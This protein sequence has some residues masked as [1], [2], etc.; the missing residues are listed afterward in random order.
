MKQNP[1]GGTHLAFC[2]IS[3]EYFT[4]ISC[5]IWS[6]NDCIFYINE[7]MIFRLAPI[8]MQVTYY[9]KSDCQMSINTR[10]SIKWQKRA[11]KRRNSKLTAAANTEIQNTCALWAPVYV[12]DKKKT[13]NEHAPIPNVGF[14]L[15]PAERQYA[16]MSPIDCALFLRIQIFAICHHF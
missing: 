15:A 10:R 12:Y 1:V 14:V 13:I 3:A 6:F 16:T 8:V 5:H 4:A 11:R 9:S 2:Q 7:N